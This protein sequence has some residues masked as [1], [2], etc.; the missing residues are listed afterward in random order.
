MGCMIFL[1]VKRGGSIRINFVMQ[2]YLFWIPIWSGL[3]MEY[4]FA[5][6]QLNWSMVHSQQWRRIHGWGLWAIV[7]PCKRNLLAM[8]M[9]V[10][11][12]LLVH[13]FSCSFWLASIWSYPN[14]THNVGRHIIW[15]MDLQ[16]QRLR[17]RNCNLS[18]IQMSSLPGS[19]CKLI[20][21]PN[22]TRSL[23][24]NCDLGEEGEHFYE[25]LAA[26]QRFKS[27]S[28][29]GARLFELL[30]RDRCDETVQGLGSLWYH[31][32]WFDWCTTPSSPI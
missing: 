6:P 24:S 28:C 2:F 19:S 10:S 23:N 9:R 18:Q 27:H 13:S 3:V 25:V 16:V 15:W 14:V 31:S 17:Q 20:Y 8:Y 5:K 11:S 26:S 22:Y 21:F 12:V 4:D 32:L 30:R 29:W 7:G 1:N